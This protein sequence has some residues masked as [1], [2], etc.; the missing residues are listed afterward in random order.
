MIIF[1]ISHQTI[2]CDPS[3]E[4]SCRDSSDEGSQHMFYAKVTKIIPD[5]HQTSFLCRALGPA[6]KKIYGDFNSLYKASKF[7][8]VLQH[9][10]LVIAGR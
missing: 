9:E 1:F 2:C 5:Y 3:S 10:A 6:L 4:L 8:V 7:P